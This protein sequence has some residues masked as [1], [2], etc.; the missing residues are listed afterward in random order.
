M[1]L[2]VAAFLLI[3]VLTG[4]YLYIPAK[5]ESKPYKKIQWVELMPK[6]DADALYNPPQ[7]LLDIPEEIESKIAKGVLES[8]IMSKDSKYQEALSSK[9]VMEEF[10]NQDI[11]IPGF[12]VPVEI[13]EAGKTTG[14][15][16]VP[17]FGA[18]LHY[19]PPPPN[20]TI[21]A[22]YSEGF[23]IREMYRPFIYKG[24]ITITNKKHKIAES[25]YNL[26]IDS[27]DIF[28]E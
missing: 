27:I 5:T 18:C 8:L 26:K 6:E 20:Q 7:V 4:V 28:D 2:K 10:N 13:N 9:K 14:F 16:I 1:K 24:T 22:Q 15:F 21:Y 3:T 19:P 12:V 23:D 25:A 17:Y 11:Q